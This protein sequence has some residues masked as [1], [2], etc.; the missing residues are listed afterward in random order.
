MCPELIEWELRY[1]KRHRD[2]RSPQIS[3]FVREIRRRNSAGYDLA[4]I[5]VVDIN[6]N[7][8]IRFQ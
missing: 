2:R 5:H 6:G 1:A 8:S 7:C 4:S 3:D